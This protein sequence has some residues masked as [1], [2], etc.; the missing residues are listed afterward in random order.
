MNL[1][2]YVRNN[3]INYYDLL[4]LVD[5]N[6]LNKADPGYG[7]GANLPTGSNTFIFLAHGGINGYGLY[8]S[9][10]SRLPIPLAIVKKKIEEAGHKA[11]QP[12]MAFACHSGEGDNLEMMKQL[13]KDLN[14]PVIASTRAITTDDLNSAGTWVRITPDGQVSQFTPNIR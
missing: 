13:A 12:I 6:L 14:S 2:G 4:G 3:P 7:E 10:L 5:L 8:S 1:Y 9:N 11:G